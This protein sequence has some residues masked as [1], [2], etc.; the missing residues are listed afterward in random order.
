MRDCFHEPIQATLDTARHRCERFDAYLP[1]HRE[2]ASALFQL[3]AQR[4]SEK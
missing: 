4:Q 3:V 1:G 2:M